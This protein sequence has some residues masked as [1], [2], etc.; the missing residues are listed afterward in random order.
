M[1]IVES[2][3]TYKIIK[4]GDVQVNLNSTAEFLAVFPQLSSNVEAV[5]IECEE[6]IGMRNQVVIK[7][8][9]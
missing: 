1:Q 5:S 8:C 6:N 2:Y 4:L 9:K 3:G 7:K